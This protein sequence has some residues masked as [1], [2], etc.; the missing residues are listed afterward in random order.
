MLVNPNNKDIRDIPGLAP[1]AM[2]IQR[3][4]HVV[5]FK[6]K[7]DPSM[8]VKIGVWILRAS[9]SVLLGSSG[10]G[11]SA[12]GFVASGFVGSSAPACSSVL[13]VAGF[14]CFFCDNN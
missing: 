9:P 12:P 8:L 7:T 5:T 4:I 1:P 6:S 13:L 11:S 10:S 2:E 3:S 14:V